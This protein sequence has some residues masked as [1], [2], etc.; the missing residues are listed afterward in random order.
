MKKLHILFLFLIAF[1]ISY[2]L[3][4]QNAPIDAKATKKTDA[5]Y[6][7]LQEISNQGVL[8]GHQDD[9]AYGVG[10]KD[11]KGRSDVKDVCGSYPALYGWDVSK[12]GSSFNIDT[13][14]FEKM[15]VWIKEA[16]K[17]GGI[18]TIS[19]H[20]DNPATGGSSWDNT[21]AISKILPGGEKHEFYKQ[22]LDLFANFLNDL[23]VGF[24]T[25]I[26]IIFRPF[27]EHT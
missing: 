26:P 13:V 1:Q 25:K 21:P 20:M 16:F 12:L 6:I 14:D 4:G 17:R 5:L 27:H 8:F 23:K 15:K 10:W 11:E 9:V 24:G 22:R 7:N 19:W 2:I 3:S 18:N